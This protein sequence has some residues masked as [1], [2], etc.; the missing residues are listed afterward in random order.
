[1]EQT[2]ADTPEGFS[3]DMHVRVYPG[4][5]REKRGVVVED[6][7]DTVGEAVHIADTHIAGPARRWAVQLENGDLVFVDDDEL[8]AG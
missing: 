5:D 4:T 8:V 2:M 3:I 7:G 6:F 1:M